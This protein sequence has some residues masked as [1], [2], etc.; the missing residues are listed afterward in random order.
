MFLCLVGFYFPHFN[1]FQVA[2]FL[3]QKAEASHA[4]WG[5]SVMLS[6]WAV[7][8]TWLPSYCGPNIGAVNAKLASLAVYLPQLDTGCC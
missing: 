2:I 6:N 8:Q 1:I 5:S 7:L 4:R 3:W